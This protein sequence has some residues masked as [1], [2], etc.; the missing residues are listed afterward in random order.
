MSKES[1]NSKP[2]FNLAALVLGAVMILAIFVWAAPCSGQ[3]ELANGNFV[4]MKCLYTGK[5]AVIAGI[6]LMGAGLD[7]LLKKQVSPITITVIGILLFVLP[8]ANII[9]IGV[10]VKEGMAC[11]ASAIWMK[12]IGALTVIDGIACFFVKWRHDL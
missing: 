6:I 1:C 9:G 12:I 5:A 2:I 10:C 3:L 11:H 8:F 4:P 7:G